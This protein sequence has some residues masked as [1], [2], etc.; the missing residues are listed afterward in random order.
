[1]CYTSGMRNFLYLLILAASAIVFGGCGCTSQ[2]VEPTPQAP[3]QEAQTEIEAEPP[4]LDGI[5]ETKQLVPELDDSG[6]AV[7]DASGEP[8]FETKLIMEGMFQGVDKPVRVGERIPGTNYRMTDNG[9]E[10]LQDADK[11][12]A[13]GTIEPKKIEGDD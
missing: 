4:V 8:V 13:R 5:V 10:R 1:M 6:N 12:G 7:L 9:I 3:A 11:P 2:S